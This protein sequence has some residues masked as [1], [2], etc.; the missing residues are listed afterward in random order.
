[1]KTCYLNLLALLLVIYPLGAAEE[2]TLRETIPVRDAELL[3]GETEL[4]VLTQQYE[5]VLTRLHEDRWQ[6]VML[7]LLAR[8][9]QNATEAQRDFDNKRSGMIQLIEK[10]TQWSDE[11]RQRIEQKVAELN[12]REDELH[13]PR[14]ETS[15]PARG[16]PPPTKKEPPKSPSPQ[17]PDPQF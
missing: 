9:P 11:L 10:R 1:M 14:A 6:L 15:A 5:K 8:P 16:T 7:D 12:K 2:R 17:A 3:L 4:R 13:R